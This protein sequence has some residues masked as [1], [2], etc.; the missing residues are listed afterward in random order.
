VRPDDLSGAERHHH[1]A[2][3]IQLDDRIDG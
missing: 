2:A 3:R 1:L